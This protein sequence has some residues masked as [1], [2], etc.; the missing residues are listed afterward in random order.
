MYL[1]H[2]QINLSFIDKTLTANLIVMLDPNTSI[3]KFPDG[4]TWLCIRWLK[5]LNT[6]ILFV[7]YSGAIIL[8]VSFKPSGQDDETALHDDLL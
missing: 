1:M 2:S 4:L 5:A 8:N 6:L 7:K 3:I